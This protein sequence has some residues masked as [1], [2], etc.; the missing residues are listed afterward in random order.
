MNEPRAPIDLSTFDRPERSQIPLPRRRWAAVLV[1]LLIL[2]AVAAIF[3]W[4]AGSLFEKPRDVTVVRPRSGVAQTRGGEAVLQAAGWVEPDPFPTL[5]NAL[6]PGIVAELLVEESDRVAAGDPVARLVADDARL[7]LDAAEAAL[8]IAKAARDAQLAELATARRSFDEKV[9]LTEALETARASYEGKRVEVVHRERQVERAR[10]DLELASRRLEIQGYLK[11]EG[12]DGP[13][14]VEVAELGRRQAEA[15]LAIE[16]ADRELARHDAEEAAARL[17]RAE[18]D[19]ELRLADGLRVKRAEAAVAGAEAAVAAAVTARDEAA[20]RLERM[21]VRA[22]LGGVV[23][24]RTSAPGSMVGM[25]DGSVPVCSLFDP[26][27][28]RIR[29]DVPQTRIGLVSAGQIAEMLSQARPD[30]PY[31]G[32]VIRIVQESDIQKVTLQVHVRVTDPDDLLRPEMLCTARFLAPAS[33]LPADAASRDVVLVPERLVGDG[34]VWV[35]GGDGESAER[36]T[37]ELGARQGDLV[38]VLSGLDLSA[39]IIDRGREGLE[40]GA[41]VRIMEND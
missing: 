20:L 31:R 1:P 27:R 4:S 11:Q 34:T 24:A 22:P 16:E 6:A 35:V 13:W 9:E 23:L 30:R 37:V 29:V 8:G 21:T 33:S 41:P 10:I 17:R 28:I 2:A 40:S 36:R 19:L 5:V 26:T 25:V 3:W 38:E 32:E 14:Q 15:Q 18:R 39:K 7:A 12:A